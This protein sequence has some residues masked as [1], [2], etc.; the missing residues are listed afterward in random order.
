LHSPIKIKRL[1]PAALL[2]GLATLGRAANRE[3]LLP[4]LMRVDSECN[5]LTQR[6]RRIE[7]F[8]ANMADDAFLVNRAI[9]GK[10]ETRAIW[11]RTDPKGLRLI[12]GA[13]YADVSAAGDLGYTLGVW[14]REAPAG[15][16][17][18]IKSSSGLFLTV[19]K[20]Q[21]DGSWKFVVDGGAVHPPE[22]IEGVRRLF[23]P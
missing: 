3:S 15:D 2:L 16:T 1:F 21:A 6:V 10:A 23:A 13:T 8:L 14:Q 9:H 22:V 19:W 17:G 4:D 7:G 18:E 5:S 20:R 11:E 12:W